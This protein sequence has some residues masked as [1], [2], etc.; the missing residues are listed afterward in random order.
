MANTYKVLG[1]VN[2]SDTTNANLYTVPSGTATVVSTLIIT[3]VTATEAVARVYV[4]QAAAVAT[5][6]NAIAYDVAVPKNSLNTF[7]LGITL[8]ATDVVTVHSATANAL[9]FHLFGSEVS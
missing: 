8:G 6:G 7:T 1:Q 4:R 5:T 9:A 3:N 2:P